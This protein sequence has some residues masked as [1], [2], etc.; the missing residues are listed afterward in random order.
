MLPTQEQNAGSEEDWNIVK[1]KKKTHNFVPKN[2]EIIHNRNPLIINNNN[3]N[4]KTHYN[5][6]VYSFI[7]ESDI[8]ILSSTSDETNSD[9]E[10]TTTSTTT[11]NIAKESCIKPANTYDL[12]VSNSTLK[13]NDI[14]QLSKS[15][16]QPKHDT[17]KKHTNLLHKSKK[18]NSKDNLRT[19]FFLTRISYA[20]LHKFIFIKQCSNQ[21]KHSDVNHDHELSLAETL[22]IFVL[23][24]FFI[25]GVWKFFN[26]LMI[27]LFNSLRFIS[28]TD[29]D[30]PY[31]NTSTKIITTFHWKIDSKD[32][33]TYGNIYMQPGYNDTMTAS[34]DISDN[35]KD[36]ITF[37]SKLYISTIPI[38]YRTKCKQIK[39]TWKPHGEYLIDFD[40]QSIYKMDT[41]GIMLN[42]YE[43]LLRESKTHYDQIKLLFE[44]EINKD[45]K[46]WSVLK[47]YVETIRK[48][49]KKNIKTINWK[50]K[51]LGKST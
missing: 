38:K 36:T 21:Q 10:D 4:N 26:L 41:V 12:V 24:F 14:L 6:F 39:E 44:R 33:Q 28:N 17:N 37:E 9:F 31:S 16:E 18:R 45:A 5:R 25:L 51:L 43:K 1:R 29:K 47:S 50:K 49:T 40:A 11:T 27:V 13:A 22:I 35:D 20:W 15:F 34:D 48:T 19:P 7:K 32:L 42:F 2:E 30:S 46:R 23:F 8:G 3:N